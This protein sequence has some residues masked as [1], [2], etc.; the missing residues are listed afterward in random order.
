MKRE[1]DMTEEELIVYRDIPENSILS[2]IVWLMGHYAERESAVK[3]RRL[4]FD[5]MH[6]LVEQAAMMGYCGNLW[7][8]YLADL[9]VNNEN[10]YSRA[11]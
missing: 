10:A 3:S 8:C 7:H 6:R 2:D 9:L 1:G 4:L 5:C 11:L